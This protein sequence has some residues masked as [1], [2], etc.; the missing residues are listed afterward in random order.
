MRVR[1]RVHGGRERAGKTGKTGKTGNAILLKA[2]SGWAGWLAGWLV[3][4]AEGVS[5]VTQ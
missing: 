3:S 2:V 1:V 4:L 5:S